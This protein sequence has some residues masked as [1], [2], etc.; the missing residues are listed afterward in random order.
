M[1]NL[2]RRR[3]AAAVDYGLLVG[4]IAL[5]VLV[6]VSQTG[7][8]ISGLMTA[9]SNALEGSLDVPPAGS[10][11]SNGTGGAP[12]DSADVPSG[13]QVFTASTTW[14]VPDGVTQLRVLAVGGGGGGGSRFAGGGASGGV[15]VGSLSVT[16]GQQIA[17]TVGAAGTGGPNTANT[18]GTDGGA[19]SFG[20]IVAGGGGGSAL[21]APGVA[22]AGGSGGGGGNACDAY[23]T[24]GMGGTA[25]SAGD[26]S[27]YGPTNHYNACASGG[28]GGGAAALAQFTG[29]SVQYAPG[30]AGFYGNGGDAL[31]HS[32]GSG[33]GGGGGVTIDGA[34]SGAPDS[35][36]GYGGKGFGA[37]GA[38]GNFTGQQLYAGSDGAAGVIY[39]EW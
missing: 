22:P 34:G 2:R 4:L 21:F 16:P 35:S 33:G 13:R 14:T 36:W 32:G 28:A 17:V 20:A 10:G 39:I 11:G 26:A 38:G 7:T 18:P 25:G 37:G 23:G 3:G 19:S 30:G 9:A 5:A 15:T 1:R 12:Q 24:S 27:H 29:A 6:A 31:N 8:A